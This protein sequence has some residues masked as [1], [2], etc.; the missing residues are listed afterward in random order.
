MYKKLK[1]CYIIFNK[2]IIP[3]ESKAKK[4]VLYIELKKINKK[5]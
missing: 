1:I 3:Q 5:Y 2:S 4:R